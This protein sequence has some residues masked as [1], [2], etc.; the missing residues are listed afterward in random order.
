MTYTIKNIGDGDAGAS[1]TCIYADG[2]LLTTDPVGA[3]AAGKSYT[4]TVTIDPF[5]CPCGKT[6]VI[7]V[8][9]DNYDDVDESDEN[10]NCLE[11]NLKCPPCPCKEPDLTIIEKSEAWVSFDDTTYTITYTVKN[12]GDG[13]AAASTTTITI[14]GV[15]V[16]TDS[17]PEL[18]SGESYS[19]TL[20]PFTIQGHCDTIVVCADGGDKVDESNEGNNCRRNMLCQPVTSGDVPALTPFGAAILIGSLSLF[21]VAS[22]RRRDE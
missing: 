15:E 19:N 6:I 14:N 11:N 2:A 13:D 9:A 12:N 8:C 22:M 4:R 7:N 5:D 17:V 21:A 20:G 10:N 16:A 1:T 18:A 3:L